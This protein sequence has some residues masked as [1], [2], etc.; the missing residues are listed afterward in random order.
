MNVKIIDDEM[1][2]N[3]RQPLKRLASMP[4]LSLSK[5][6]NDGKVHAIPRDMGP[7]DWDIMLPP[8]DIMIPRNGLAKTSSD[9]RWPPIK[10]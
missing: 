4:K 3:Q 8:S 9:A 1:N 2:I 5:V 7:A 6:N 10:P